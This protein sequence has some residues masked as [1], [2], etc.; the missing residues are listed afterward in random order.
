MT[1]RRGEV[2]AGSQRS[3]RVPLV[4]GGSVQAEHTLEEPRPVDLGYGADAVLPLPAGVVSGSRLRFM[5]PTEDG[6]WEVI[7]HPSMQGALWIDGGRRSVDELRGA[8]PRV[9]VGP[10]DYGVLTLG[11]TAIFFQQVRP[12]SRLGRRLA[13]DGNALSSLGLSTFLH[14]AALLLLF[15]AQREAPVA[16]PL[17]LPDDLLRRF[18]AMPPVARVAPPEPGSE[19]EAA[20]ASLSDEVTGDEGARGE[21]RDRELARAPRPRRA[22][23]DPRFRNSVLGVLQ[24][25][26]AS[27]IDDALSD[28]PDVASLLGALRP[29]GL[30]RGHGRDPGDGLRGDGPT[31][32][33]P[34]RYRGGPIATD[35]GDGRG[36]DDSVEPRAPHE[37][38]VTLPPPP[39][40]EGPGHLPPSAILRVVRRNQRAILYCYE[41]QLQRRR[42]LRGRV[43]V[44]W[45]IGLDGHTDRVR[46]ERSTLGDPR[47]EGCMT[48]QIRGWR[49]DRPDGGPVDVHFPFL[50]E[51]D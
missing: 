5:E 18:L 15:L 1:S 14:A 11:A 41:S 13:V 31:G 4:F 8:G 45:R 17:E 35:V 3:L 28:G 44:S 23:P 34:R 12:A 36:L 20:S 43:E 50:F 16:G 33:G 40:P 47:V 49:F 38:R 21:P 30:V 26:G 22:R 32:R 6:G 37:T 42:S 19:L 24:S 9:R 2:I 27:A 46:L 48:R 51:S 25:G 7:L 39:P 29:G 10:E